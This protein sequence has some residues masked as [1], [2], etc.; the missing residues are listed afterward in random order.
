M[1]DIDFIK[2]NPSIF[3]KAMESR[4]LL[5]IAG[6]IIEL[7]NT[8]RQLLSELYALREQRNIIAKEVPLLMK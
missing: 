5:P 8:R 2:N 1:H 7:D 3:D 6:E 4:G